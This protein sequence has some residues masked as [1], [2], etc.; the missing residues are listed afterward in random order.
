MTT[1]YWQHVE[2]EDPA[3]ETARRELHAPTGALGVD[4]AFLALL[5]SG[6]TVAVSIALDMYSAEERTSR[7]GFANPL[8]EH[9]DEVLERAREVLRRPPMPAT[10][11]GAAHDGADH[12][13]AL[14]AMMNLARPDDADLLAA[15]LRAPA[16]S[17]VLL[18]ACMAADG[19]LWADE[20]S[21]ELIAA[22]GEIVFDTA[23]TTD[24]RKDALRALGNVEASSAAD[25]AVRAAQDEDAELRST[26]V[27]VLATAH[28]S[29]HRPLV[30][31]F[32][33]ACPRTDPNY[34]NIRDQLEDAGNA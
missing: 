21:S 29:T 2:F 27:A 6:R 1:H 12:A 32:F 22:L 25:I 15:V 9:A 7:W 30:E 19:A 24:Q 5:R 20:P 18:T 8:Q 26:A 16:S 14:G 11:S 23:R 31:E 34:L 28:L 13:S 3:L 10:D 33:A 17:E 4:E